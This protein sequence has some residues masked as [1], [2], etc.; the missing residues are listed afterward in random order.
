M[1]HDGLAVEQDTFESAAG[2]V[3]DAEGKFSSRGI[4]YLVKNPR[5]W[6]RNRSFQDTFMD[7]CR[8]ISGRS[9]LDHWSGLRWS[10]GDDSN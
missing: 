6:E 10:L 9:R 8:P 3:V 2:T 5:G 1:H 4:G 7:R